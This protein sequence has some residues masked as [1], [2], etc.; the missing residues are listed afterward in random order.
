MKNE[1]EKARRLLDSE[2]R[3]ERGRQRGLGIRCW[4]TA[5]TESWTYRPNDACL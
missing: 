5:Q 4:K 3:N 1:D 2:E